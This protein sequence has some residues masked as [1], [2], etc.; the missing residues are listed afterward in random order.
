MSLLLIQNTHNGPASF[1]IT[2]GYSKLSQ[3]FRVDYIYRELGNGVGVM[4]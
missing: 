1:K 2:H 4:D 3:L